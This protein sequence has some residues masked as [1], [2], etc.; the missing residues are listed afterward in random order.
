MIRPF[1][2]KELYQRVH[3]HQSST[4]YED[5]FTKFIPRSHMPKDYGGEL[6]TV[7]ELHDQNRQLLIDMREYFIAEE[8]QM[9]YKFEDHVVEPSSNDE[10]QNEFYDAKDE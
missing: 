1:I 2:R 7:Q 6:D 9:N 3:L 5:F 4:D 8:D 10:S